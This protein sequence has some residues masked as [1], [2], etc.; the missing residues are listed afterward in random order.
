MA[1][2]KTCSLVD[3]FSKI[4]DFRINRKKRHKLVDIMT[5]AICAVICGANDWNAIE[6]FGKAKHNWF[7]N[8]LELP[9]GIPSHDTFNRVF[10]LL[11]PDVFQEMTRLGHEEPLQPHGLAGREQDA[12]CR[13]VPAHGRCRSHR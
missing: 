1:N 2:I 13:A 5:I 4:P 11:R 6:E 12:V 3:H 8:F 10:G 9:H 7:S